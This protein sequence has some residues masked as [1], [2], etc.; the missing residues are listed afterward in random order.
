MI[1]N[2]IT[3]KTVGIDDI[4]NPNQLSIYPNPNAGDFT[5]E[6]NSADRSSYVLEMIN[7]IGQVVYK[8]EIRDFKGAYTKRLSFERIAGIYTL[9][10]SMNQNRIMKRIVIY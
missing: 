4:V 3:I 8:E 9:S 6:F 2:S 5:I 1:S 7:A 10:L